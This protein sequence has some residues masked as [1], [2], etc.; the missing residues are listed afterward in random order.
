M[1]PLPVLA[2]ALLIGAGVFA[3]FVWKKDEPEATTISSVSPAAQASA[4]APVVDINPADNDSAPAVQE[5]PARPSS[6]LTIVGDEHRFDPTNPSNEAT[7]EADAAWL[8]KF[9]FLDPEAYDRLR[10]ASMDEL[11][12]AAKVDL[13]AQV[14]L[15]YNMAAAG[16]YGDQPFVLLEDAAAR[17]SIFALV[18][19]GDIHFSLRQYRNGAIGS[20]YY[21]LALRRGYYT[22]ATKNYAIAGDL[23]AE[24]RL[25]ADVWAEAAWLRLQDARATR[26]LPPFAQPDLR[27]GFEQFLTTLEA[28]FRPNNA[29]EK[30]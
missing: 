20:A 10:K 6:L 18:T 3:L 7:S 30:K 4:P 23:S 16:G 28:S 29:S 25:I 26:G 11:K 27:P 21:K 22:A 5:R 17:G 2:C 15:A 8:H 24:Q 9:G 14:I 13:R 19:W 12:E 1:R